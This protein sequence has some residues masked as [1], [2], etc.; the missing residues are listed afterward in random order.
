MDASLRGLGT[1]LI[2]DGKPIAF[3]SKSLTGAESCY[4]NIERELLTVIFACIRFNTYLQGR[5]FTVQS[6]HKPLE[7]I[8]LKSMHNV[9]PHL[10]RMLLQLQKY[11]MEIKYKPG[12]EMLLADTLSRCPARYSQEIKLDLHVDYIAFTSAWIETLRETTCEDPVLSMVYQLVQ[13]RWPKERR[14]VPNVAKYYW[15]F[16]DELS[17]DEGLLLKG[18]SLVIPAALRENYLQH[19]HKGHLSSSKTVLNA[20]QH[21]FWPGI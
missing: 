6:D 5:R 7:M 8:H 17:T 2:Q 12:S 13:H 9:P 21:M 14:R 16:R 4:A 11:D 10:Q 20:R 15:D 1:C 19:L 3:A 18:P